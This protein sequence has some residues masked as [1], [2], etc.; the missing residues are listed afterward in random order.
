MRCHWWCYPAYPR[1]QEVSVRIEHICIITS[2]LSLLLIL[3]RI[4]L[5]P[6]IFFE[7]CGFF[8]FK[9]VCVNL[10][11]QRQFRSSLITHVDKQQ[12]GEG[13]SC[14]HT[15]EN[16]IQCGW[17]EIKFLKREKQ[18]FFFLKCRVPFI[19]LVLEPQIYP[20]KFPLLV[21]YVHKEQHD[22]CWLYWWDLPA[23][24]IF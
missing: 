19:R 13:Y 24:Q 3:L 4:S 10:Q 12:G 6:L 15:F 2:T 14:L 9:K 1:W 11:L 23:T 17:Q 18:D 7:D 16:L 21:F 20:W 5:C 22:A 8:L